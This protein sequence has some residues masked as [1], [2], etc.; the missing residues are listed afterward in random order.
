MRLCLRRRV[1]CFAGRRHGIC[2]A[3]LI[4][5]I[6]RCG[7]IHVGLA[8]SGEYSMACTCRLSLGWCRRRKIRYEDAR[9]IQDGAPG[10]LPNYKLP[11]SEETDFCIFIHCLSHVFSLTCKWGVM[12]WASK[13]IVDSLHNALK[14]CRNS[15][16]GLHGTAEEFVNTRT[17]PAAA[18]DCH[19]V[20]DRISRGDVLQDGRCLQRNISQWL[21]PMPPTPGTGPMIQG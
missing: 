20:E 3:L 8:C 17:V 6:C 14:A 9:A 7:I 11:L 5:C 21:T 12:P 1:R 10:D 2:S 13:D 18:N 19:V 16:I 4:S 15:S